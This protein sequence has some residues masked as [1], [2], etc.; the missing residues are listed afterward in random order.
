MDVVRI[1]WWCV[2]PVCDVNNLE[3]VLLSSV[4]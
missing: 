4:V 3:M 1:V 2:V